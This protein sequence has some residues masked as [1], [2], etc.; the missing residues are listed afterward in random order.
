M[1]IFDSEAANDA[2]EI[3]FAADRK[4]LSDLTKYFE[5]HAKMGGHLCKEFEEDFREAIE[6]M[7]KANV[8]MCTIHSKI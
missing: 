4:K 2:V 8:I 6:C 1:Y 7:E 3:V 5:A